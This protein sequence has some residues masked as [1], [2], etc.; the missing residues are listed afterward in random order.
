MRKRLTEA[1]IA[2][3]EKQVIDV[4]GYKH[5]TVWGI[6]SPKGK[7]LRC[8]ERI[9]GTWQKVRKEPDILTAEKLERA[10]TTDRRFV[11]ILGG[12]GSMKST[13]VVDI[14]LANVMDNGDK[15]YCLREYQESISES[16]HSLNK[17]E[18]ARLELEGF[19]IQEAAIYHRSGGA[20]KYRGLSRN[21]ESIKSA[22]GF[23][24]FFSEESAKLS[25][26]S[27]MN[28]T[29]TARNKAK[30][31]LPGQQKEAKDNLSAVQMYFVANPGSMEDPFSQRFINPFLGALQKDGFYEDDLHTVIWINYLDNPWFEES[32]LEIE[33][34]FDYENKPRAIYDHIWLGAFLDTIDDAII[35]AEWFDACIDAHVVLGFDAQGQEKVAFDPADSGDAKAIAYQ[36][37]VVIKG[38][39]QIEH[40]DVHDATNWATGKTNEIRPDVFIWDGD[41]MGLSLKQ[42]IHDAF[43][44]KKIQAVPFIGSGGVWEKGEQY[45]PIEGESWGEKPKTNAE[46]FTNRRAQA[47]WA[48]RDRVFKTYLAVVKKRYYPPDELISFSSSIKDLGALRAEIC[49]IPRKRVPSGKIQILDKAAMKAMKLKSPNLADAV[50]MLQLPVDP[51]T[52]DEDYYDETAP[53]DR[54]Y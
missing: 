10:I 3:A 53:A 41:G 8:I 26:L 14:M 31:G 52:V 7:L 1:A 2:G 40:G 21:P 48:L 16:V 45:N 33:R 25:K 28:L 39:A 24:K 17:D 50:M 37:G 42:Q 22:A 5:S 43:K 44:G 51:F 4:G 27:I 20:V 35:D 38:C 15:V 30:R 23:T 32:G 9:D 34:Q 29:P 54:W 18:I 47:Y 13:G 12:R 11:V 6:V 46:M 19:T 49:R 36:H